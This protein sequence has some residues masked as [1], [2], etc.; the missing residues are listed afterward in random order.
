MKKVL[1]L[2]LAFVMLL[3]LAA[4]GGN[5]EKEPE[6]KPDEGTGLNIDMSKYPTDIN[7]WSGQNFVDYFAE[8]GVFTERAGFESWIQDHTD[9]WP[10]T[11]VNECIGYWD[12]DGEGNM[13]MI[14]VLK[15]DIADAGEDMYKEWM[16][17]LKTSKKLPGDYGNLGTVDH[18]VGNVVFM[19]ENTVFNDGILADMTAAYNYLVEKLGVTPEF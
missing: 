19:F 6:K 15:S 14:F 12:P 10:E 5:S 9:Y 1:A 18:L 16:D 13:I 17:S 11:P 4:C 8:A 2:T 7:A 3:S